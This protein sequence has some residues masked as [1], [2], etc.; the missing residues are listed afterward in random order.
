MS[1]ALLMAAIQGCFAL[2]QYD[3]DHTAASLRQDLLRS[4]PVSGM[5]EAVYLTARGKN[6][7]CTYDFESGAWSYDP[8]PD[9]GAIRGVDSNGR[10][11]LGPAHAIVHVGEPTRGF[12]GALD[13][14]FPGLF[15]RDMLSRPGALYEAK[16]LPEGGW[17]LEFTLPRGQRS[18][19]PGMPAPTYLPRNEH[20]GTAPDPVRVFV[21]DKLQVTR[22]IYP[23]R[24]PLIYTRA[25]ESPMGFQVTSS[26]PS[27]RVPTRLEMCRYSP[28]SDPREFSLNTVAAEVKARRMADLERTPIGDIDNPGPKPAPIRAATNAPIIRPWVWIAVGSILVALAIG[29]WIRR[30]MA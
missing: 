18:T 2:A 15:L 22:M 23:G 30:R 12:D 29:A 26:C 6:L 19:F 17:E 7:V 20:S 28:T 16:K 4:W 13:Y 27:Q 25:P 5:V 11:Y 10:A 1:T 24:D 8:S 21:D 3:L 9:S 14:W